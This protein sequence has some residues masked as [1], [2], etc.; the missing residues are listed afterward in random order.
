MDI[1]KINVDGPKMSGK[2]SLAAVLTNR[3]DARHEYISYKHV[4]S[5]HEYVKL[6]NEVPYRDLVMERGVL[7]SWIYTFLRDGVFIAREPGHDWAKPLTL[8]DFTTVIQE[9]DLFAILYT[10]DVDV[11]TA[12]LER[13]IKETGKGATQQERDELAITNDAFYYWGQMFKNTLQLRNVEMYDVSNYDSIAELESVIYKDACRI[14][15]KTEIPR[16][17]EG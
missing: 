3:F 14:S 10:S 12:R 9:F 1:M 17:D 2:S 15:G 11:L 7:S 16:N 13:R 8:S 6:I 5:T 4:Y